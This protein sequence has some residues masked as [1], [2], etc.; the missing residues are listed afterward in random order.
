MRVAKHHYVLAGSI[1]LFIAVM[2][3]SLAGC[4]PDKKTSVPDPKLPNDPPSV[5]V[6]KGQATTLDLAG[7]AYL[8]IPPGA[9]DPGTTVRA[10]YKGMP[11]G[12]G[13]IS[14]RPSRRSSSSP[15]RRTRSMVCSSLSS[16]SRRRRS[17]P[18]WIQP[19]NSES[20]PTMRR[21]RRGHL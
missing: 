1:L 10:T 18:G 3:S 17:S 8:I 9:M 13:S 2:V 19:C 12:S 20:P 16:L 15:T 4:G 5:K 6:V 7:G 11:N 21:R 14:L